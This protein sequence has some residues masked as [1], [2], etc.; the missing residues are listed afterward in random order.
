MQDLGGKLGGQVSDADRNYIEAR[1]PQLRNSPMARA[2]LIA[3]LKEIH[4]KNISYYKNMSSHANK[5]GNLNEFNFAENAP[6]TAS[7]ALGTK[8]NPIK[9]Q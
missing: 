2:E 6:S 3:K 1:I 4:K 5:Y 9:L 7:P 8:E